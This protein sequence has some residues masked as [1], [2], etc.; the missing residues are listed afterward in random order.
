M[1][2]VESKSSD[3]D[4]Q[5]IADDA[6]LY[7]RVPPEHCRFIGG[8]VEVREGAF[9]NFPHPELKRMSV[10]LGDRLAELER[11]PRTILKG[12]EHCG[13]VVLRAGPLRHDEEQKLQRTPKPEEL[14][15][16]D[17]VGDKPASRKKRLAAMAEWVIRPPDP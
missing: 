8:E 10:V 12:H 6:E 17:V 13:V 2:E 4:D 1:A 9:K 15:H 16:G 3:E 11:D 7:R 5:S 14:A